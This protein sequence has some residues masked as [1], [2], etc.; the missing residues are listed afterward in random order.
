MKI[1]RHVN[2]A[3]MSLLNWIHQIF[4]NFNEN[5]VLTMRNSNSLKQTIWIPIFYT[6]FHEFSMIFKKLFQKFSKFCDHAKIFD[7]VKLWLQ[8]FPRPLTLRL[9]I[10]KVR[11]I[12]FGILRSILGRNSQLKIDFPIKKSIFPL[13]FWI[14]IFS[15]KL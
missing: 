15:W 2:H 3:K 5:H 6:D 14:K 8:N 12:R 4:I 7:H 13:S 10:L 9:W 11:S 1:E